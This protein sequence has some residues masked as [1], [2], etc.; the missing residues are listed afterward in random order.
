MNPDAPPT[1]PPPAP[2]DHQPP[3]PPAYPPHPAPGPATSSIDEN[4]WVMLTHLSPIVTG[5]VGPLVVWLLKKDQSPRIGDQAKET[6]N[7]VITWT[8]AFLAILIGGGIVAFALSKISGIV[9]GIFGG[10]V[11]LAYL[12]LWVGGLVL[13]IKAAMDANKGLDTRYRYNLRLIK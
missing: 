1:P 9:A 12:G 2:A 6:L 5:F 7:F 8:I 3:P 10:V 13:I 4:Q 11:W